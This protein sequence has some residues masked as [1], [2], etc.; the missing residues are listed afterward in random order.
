MLPEWK[1]F[2]LLITDVLVLRLSEASQ[3]R[4]IEAKLLEVENQLPAL[5]FAQLYQGR[6]QS[7]PL[8]IGSVMGNDLL[9]RGDQGELLHRKTNVVQRGL[10][11]FR[12]LALP[13]LEQSIDGFGV[14]V[15]GR[16]DASGAARPHVREQQRLVSREHPEAGKI[17]QHRFEVGAFAGAVL[18]AD[19][20]AG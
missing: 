19:D 5:R 3:A 9:E 6:A 15:G 17:A 10:D 16:R 14:D 8:R 18:H 1:K 7:I 12:I 13:A 2:F 20:D 4:H 11:S